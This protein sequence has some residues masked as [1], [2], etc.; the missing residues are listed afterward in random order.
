MRQ[1]VILDDSLKPFCCECF[2]PFT[3]KTSFLGI[4]ICYTIMCVFCRRK[5]RA[6]TMKKAIEKWNRGL[7]SDVF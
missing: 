6:R 5:I 4:P 7:Q 3:Y 1:I 2:I